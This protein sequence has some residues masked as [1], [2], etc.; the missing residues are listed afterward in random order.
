MIVLVIVFIHVQRRKSAWIGLMPCLSPDRKE[1]L[2]QKIGRR[3][4]FRTFGP[5]PSYTREK[6]ISVRLFT[7]LRG[8]TSSTVTVEKKKSYPGLFD[9]LRRGRIPRQRAG[10]ALRDKRCFEARKRS[11]AAAEAAGGDACVTSDQVERVF[12]NAG[13]RRS[14]ACQ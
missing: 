1:S 3:L 8:R 9:V 2:V 10:G 5:T 12:Y 4:G 13:F 7:L 6:R 14:R 11:D